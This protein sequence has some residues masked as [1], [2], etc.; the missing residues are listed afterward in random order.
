MATP[1]SEVISYLRFDGPI[2]VGD[3][4]LTIKV[5]LQEFGSISITIVT[6]QNISF[7]IEFSNDGINFDYRNANSIFIDNFITITSPILGK[8]CRLR[9]INSSPNIANVRFTSYAQ[10][11][12]IA[13]QAQIEKEGNINPSVNV[14]NLSTSMNNNLRIC[15]RKPLYYQN[16]TYFSATAGV[17]SGPN[18]SLFQLNGGGASYVNSPATIVN[19]NLTLSNIY[20]EAAG[21]YH[22]VYSF[23][24]LPSYG[25]PV[26]I[27]FSSKFLISGYTNGS[28]LGYDQMLCGLGYVDDSNGNIVDGMFIGYPS[29]PIAPNPIVDE[30][31]FIY[32]SNGVEIAI[33]K[34]QWIFDRLDGNCNSGITLDSTKLNT[35]RIR[36]FLGGSI[37][38]EMHD[39]DDNVWIPCHRVIIE[40]KADESPFI[41]PSFGFVMYTKRTSTASGS[42]VTNGCGPSNLVYTSGLEIG[43]SIDEKIITSS[44]ISPVL[45]TSLSVQE[46][47]SIRSGISINS[48]NNRGIIFPHNLMVSTSAGG[49]VIVD[50]YKNGTFTGGGFWTPKDSVY[51]SLETGIGDYNIGTGYRVGGFIIGANSVEKFDLIDLFTSL[52]RL[53][54]LTF[55]C[56]SQSIITDIFILLNYGYIQ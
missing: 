26:Y 21:A 28:S 12:P 1:L 54:T 29:F 2:N 44:I 49:P 55:V 6:D 36:T 38:L 13:T 32:Y 4:F 24:V 42:A 20:T 7:I 45:T 22:Y 17:L 27:E 50:I 3:Y 34:N 11:I 41:N 15:N 56:L 23:P 8:W 39:P 5:L 14:D 37:Y 40:N 16:Y 53:E 31:C 10:V 52:N 47:Y 43:N 25:N 9:A 33:P 48:I 46:I 51:E 18:R 35:W 19:N 30:I